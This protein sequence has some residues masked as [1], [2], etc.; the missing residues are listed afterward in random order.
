MTNDRATPCVRWIAYI[1]MPPSCVLHTGS[2]LY[3]SECGPST[4]TAA[5]G[6]FRN[7]NS[8]EPFPNELNQKS[9]GRA[10]EVFKTSFPDGS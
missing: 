6:K 8:H 1:R 2:A 4:A 10:Q 5:P 7:T 3:A 9:G